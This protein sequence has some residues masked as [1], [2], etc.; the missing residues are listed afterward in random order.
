MSCDAIREKLYEYLFDLLDDAERR[1]VEQHLKACKACREALDAAAR[2]RDL[3]GQWD[4]G[5]PPKG[6]ARAAVARAQAASKRKEGRRMTTYQPVER[7]G[8]LESLRK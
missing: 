8:Y 2:E 4:V 7:N 5:A 6:L 1:Q 3:L